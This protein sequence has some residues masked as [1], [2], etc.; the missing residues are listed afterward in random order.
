M[1]LVIPSVEDLSPLH[2]PLYV[3]SQLVSGQGE[4]SV[5]IPYQ[6]RS[7][8]GQRKEGGHSRCTLEDQTKQ[9]REV[10]RAVPGVHD[11]TGRK[12]PK[13]VEEEV[14]AMKKSMA[15]PFHSR[16]VSAGD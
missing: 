4:N 16:R 14:L 8:W 9:P 13:G 6:R 10:R 7:G 12:G 3:H 15:V 2:R 5:P 11:N 1:V